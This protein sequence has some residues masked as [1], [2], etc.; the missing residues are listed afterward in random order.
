[1]H[2]AFDAAFGIFD[3]PRLLELP[4][5][6]ES[7]KLALAWHPR[8]H[9]DPA[10]QWLR[11]LVLDVVSYSCIFQQLFYT[12]TCLQSHAP[13]SMYSDYLT[14]KLDL[15]SSLLVEK[16][17]VVYSDQWDL[18]VRALRVLR[19]VCAEPDITPKA[20]SQQALIEKTLLSKILAQLCARGLMVRNTH[21]ADRRSI[22]L[23]ATPEGVR[24]VKASRKLGG[25]LEAELLAVLSEQERETLNCLLT[26]LTS[27]L[28]SA[29]QAPEKED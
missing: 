6:N 9:L 13:S 15:T 8:N 18:D 28:L 24:V 11:D 1:M 22:S 20:V 16:A 25:K 2:T 10:V 4:F 3:S 21:S 5:P 19:L 14:F 26:K 29:G 12:S 27:S 7:Y 23:R 17:N